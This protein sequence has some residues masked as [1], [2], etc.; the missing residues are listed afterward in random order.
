MLGEFPRVSAGHRFCLLVSSCVLTSKFRNVGTS[1]QAVDGVCEQNTT[2]RR[3]DCVHTAHCT[4]LLHAHAWLKMFEV[5]IKY[6]PH[7][8]TCCMSCHLT[9][10][11]RL[12]CCSQLYL[13]QSHL[14][15]LA[16]AQLQFNLKPAPIHATLEVTVLRNPTL[17]QK[18][19][20]KFV[21]VATD[22][23]N[24][25]VLW[26]TNTKRKKCMEKKEPQRQKPV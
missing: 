4:D 23:K 6:V 9:C 19:E 8:V 12:P 22:T 10:T 21:L 2:Y 16:L 1:S 3:E 14:L 7:L 24:R 13:P 15:F 26:A 25:S 18:N 5:C 20:K 11:T 17:A